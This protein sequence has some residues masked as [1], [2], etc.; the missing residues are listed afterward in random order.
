MIKS[1]NLPNE[2]PLY[3]YINLFEHYVKIYMDHLKRDQTD[4]DDTYQRLPLGSS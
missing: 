2:R 1:I 4:G 3:K